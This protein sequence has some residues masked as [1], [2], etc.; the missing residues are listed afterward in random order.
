MK[1]ISTLL[2]LAFLKGSLVS[3]M[4]ASPFAFEENQP[5]GER[6]TVIL[7][8]DENVSILTDLDGTYS[9]SSPNL[10]YPWF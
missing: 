1:V 3:G 6:I 8:G 9:K 4:T 2:L 5:D 7:Y 10:H